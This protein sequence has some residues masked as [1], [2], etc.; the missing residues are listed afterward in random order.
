MRLGIT[1]Q[2][3]H[4][5]FL[6]VEV[7]IG[8]RTHPWQANAIVALF[9]RTQHDS[10]VDGLVIRVKLGSAGCSTL[11]Y[12]FEIPGSIVMFIS[13]TKT[14]LAIFDFNY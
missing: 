4:A 5:W 7:H 3:L 14:R 12:H 8:G 11:P 9:A 10:N 6:T 1:V 13:V 2:V